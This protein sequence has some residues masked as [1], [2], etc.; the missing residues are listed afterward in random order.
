MDLR[1]LQSYLYRMLLLAVVPACVPVE[2]NSESA[3]VSECGYD[4]IFGTW[5]KVDGYTDG[6]RTE[7]RLE[8]DFQLLVIERGRRMCE[9]EIVNKGQNQTSNFKADYTHQVGDQRLEI[10]YTYSTI[11]AVRAGDRSAANYRMGCS[12]R[13]PTMRL[14]YDSGLIERYELWSVGGSACD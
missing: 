6:S 5:K 13:R 7:E 12:D 3:S 8:Y 10:D 1:V 9:A 11:N 14:E 4:E 2:D